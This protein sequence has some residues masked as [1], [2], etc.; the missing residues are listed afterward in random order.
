MSAF[1]E[2]FNNIKN[3]KGL[4]YIDIAKMCD[5]D[6]SVI[7]RWMNGER[8]PVSIYKIDEIQHGLRLTS[9]EKNELE[10]AY[11]ISTYGEDKYQNFEEILKVIARMQK[12]RNSNKVHFNNGESQH[13]ICEEEPVIEKE[14]IVFNDKEDIIRKIREMLV[15]VRH[16]KGKNIRLI[17]Y[18]MSR[19]IETIFTLHASSVEGYS[20]D[21]IYLK[22]TDEMDGLEQVV[23]I[24]F[25]KNDIRIWL[26]S[27]TTDINK[28]NE[29]ICGDMLL[30]YNDDMTEGIF[31]TYTEWVQM[32]ND[33]FECIR[34]RAKLIGKK[35][36]DDIQ[37]VNT[38]YNDKSILKVIEYQPCI[39]DCIDEEFMR[40]HFYED[41]P[42]REELI[43]I[44]TEKYDY[45]KKVSSESV[46]YFCK[47]GLKDFMDTGIL[48]VFPYPVYT[49]LTLEERCH[50]IRKTV[51]ASRRGRKCHHL[52]KD[53]RMAAL[54]DIHIEHVS[55][56]DGGN[57]VADINF[58]ENRKERI[59]FTNPGIT[60]KFMDFFECLQNE[61][62]VYSREETERYMLS[63]VEEYESMQGK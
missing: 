17:T 6:V 59:V 25:S 41:I 27:E 45:E 39:K 36:V 26:S 3:K 52:I 43:S 9:D 44:I 58:S 21:Q 61:K 19:E 35:E 48:N 1:S 18:S 47:D 51:E 12:L 13:T 2:C 31:T 62:Y 11:I 56:K 22:Q 30:Q 42:M 50:I 60:K 49:P 32:E 10:K 63:V 20:I 4:R 14:F 37:C 40:S 15:E 53:E 23:D 54:K 33:T 34:N 38:N 5:V 8:L 29:I 24:A 46:F 16:K 55:D 57:V 7:F 28:I